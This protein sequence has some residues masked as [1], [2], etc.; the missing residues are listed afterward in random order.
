MKS[1]RLRGAVIPALAAV[2]VVSPVNAQ[3]QQ[4]PPLSLEAP[5][6]EVIATTPLPGLGVSIE[7]VPS[8]VQALTDN[9]IE[10]RQAVN[11][12][13]LLSRT[14]PSVNVN[15]VTGNPFQA[16]LNYRGFL[17]S[18][19]L[20]TPQGLS[21]YQDGV[22]LNEPFGDVVYWDLIPQNAISVVNL[23]PGSNPLYGLNS[24]GGA[25]SL[26][27]KTGAEYPNTS[28]QIYGG[29]WDRI[30]V[31]VEHGGY[32]D[33]IDYYFSGSYFDEDG[34]RDFSPSTVKQF[35]GKVGYDN[36]TT[37][38]DLSLSVGDSDLTGNGVTPESMLDRRRR[39]VFTIPDNT[40]KDMWMLNLTGNH[41]LNDAFRLGGN[42]YY[43]TNRIKTLN[44]DANDDYEDCFEDAVDDGLDPLDECTE[45]A[46]NNRTRTKEDVVGT[47]LQLSHLTER[48]QATVGVSIDRGKADFRQSAAEGVLDSRR[49]VVE[50]EDEELENQLDGTTTTYSI[51]LMDVF[52][53]TD[54]TA[55]TLSAR[56]NRTRVK[57]DDKLNP[58]PPNLD[59]NH[60]YNSFNPGIGITH[61]LENRNLTLFGSWNQ[62]SRAPSP[63]EL[64]CA[65]PDN[66]CSLPNA[67]QADPFLDQV[68]ART[69]EGGVRGRIGESMRWVASAY[70]TD[71]RDDIL[72]VSTGTS[73]GYF[74]NFGKT[75]RQGV[76]LGLGGS[77][78]KFDWSA[79]YA[80][81]RATF[82]SSACILGENNSSRGQS[83]DCP[84]DDEIR[85]RSGDKLPG[86]PEHQVKLA[87][88]FRATE[89]LTFGVDMSLFSSQY[90][91][92]NENNKHR[93]G[94]FTDQFGDTRTFD[95]SGKVDGYAIFNLTG[96]YRVARNWEVFA[97]VDNVFDTEY[98]TA[99]ILAE[100]P[101]DAANQFQTDPDD[102]ARET[103][104]APGAPRAV[105]VGVR[106]NIDRTPRR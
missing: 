97:R 41:M 61:T 45:T 106:F 10:Q 11:L 38:L 102:W 63:I 27:T 54:R 78:G 12:S 59:A 40:K 67:M 49:G 55:L 22:R 42:V 48:N 50:T 30:G 103:F 46:V 101:F 73:A 39:Q 1:S 80:Y 62:S 5:S 98:E 28:A 69:F 15:E 16:D 75:R 18:P 19:L 70:R 26:R 74:T 94:T 23:I 90:A 87:L 93:A 37:D 92:G 43:R 58:D 3:D 77:Q 7:Q 64:G 52:N 33:N 51:Y 105:W 44:G 66:P 25:L 81:V 24:L 20:G 4:R 100:N 17:V 65:D 72:F 83:A 35:F 34:W 14:L 6:V 53:L 29:S 47:A 79:N 21:V 88:D 60:T 31:D 56:Y 13:D 85:V 82:E 2:A 91:R 96:R 71:S 86:I 104:F 9:A 84:S 99:A 68:I 76:E 8:N 36:G 57:T 32:T 95:G 89:R